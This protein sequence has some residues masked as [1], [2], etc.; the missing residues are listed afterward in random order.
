MPHRWLLLTGITAAT[1]WA[2]G[3]AQALDPSLR[4]A[5]DLDND[6]ATGCSVDLADP[7]SPSGTTNFAGV[8]VTV[9]VGVDALSN[10]PTTQSP[11]LVSCPPIS[12]T[13]TTTALFSAPDVATGQGYK[14]SDAVAV[15]IPVELLG[16]PGFVR[17][18]VEATSTAGSS[19]VL[20]ASGGQAIT[21][22]AATSAVPGLGSLGGLALAMLLGCVGLRRARAPAARLACLGAAILLGAA[23]LRVDL[24]QANTGWISLFAGL[25]PVATDAEGDSKNGDE[26][27]DLMALFATRSGEDLVLRVDIANVEPPYCRATDAPG[28]PGCDGICQP[29]DEALSP[30]CSPIGLVDA[31]PSLAG[32]LVA[33]LEIQTWP[34][35]D[36]S[37]NPPDVIGNSIDDT[38]APQGTATTVAFEN[39]GSRGAATL[40]TSQHFIQAELDQAFGFSIA[41]VNALHLPTSATLQA[42]GTAPTSASIIIEVLTDSAVGFPN[43]PADLEDYRIGDIRWTRFHDN[44]QEVVVRNR[45]LN[46]QTQGLTLP[47]GYSVISTCSCSLDFNLLAQYVSDIR[48]EFNN[49]HEV[50]FYRTLVLAGKGTGGDPDAS[51]VSTLARADFGTP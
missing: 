32:T 33:G 15:Q 24:A 47:A 5:L 29:N 14:G 30:D 21:F 35:Y 3:A 4:I 37:A 48:A 2:A 44:S 46:E 43:D 7:A 9:E 39:G 40:D 11:Q 6:A 16:H 19:D 38:G 17:A 1:L 22:N 26:T 8:E 36:F 45:L 50:A 41:R 13:P 18:A 34:T 42:S 20:L 28:D 51:T 12:G 10:P 25:D 49:A 31:L 23:G 27:T